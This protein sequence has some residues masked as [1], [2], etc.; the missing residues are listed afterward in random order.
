MP[1]PL[2]IATLFL[3]MLCV[4]LPN[5][6]LFAMISV[7]HFKPLPKRV[8]R[9]DDELM[10]RMYFDPKAELFYIPKK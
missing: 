5:I 7:E 8:K 4:V 3:M 1:Y 2:I 6:V 9:M 10:E